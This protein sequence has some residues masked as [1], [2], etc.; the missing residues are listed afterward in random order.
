MKL[1]FM[2]LYGAAHASSWWA[3]SVFYT[4]SQDNGYLWVAPMIMTI[5]AAVVSGFYV[6]DHWN[7]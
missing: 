6:S 7:D 1:P 2:Y 5:V 4:S 3:V